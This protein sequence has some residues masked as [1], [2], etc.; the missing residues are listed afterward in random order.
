MLLKASVVLERVIFYALLL[1]I[2]IVATPYGVVNPWR[3]VIETIFECGI[4]ALGAL[5]MIE[6]MLS[7]MWVT[8]RHLLLLPLLAIAV[9]AYVQTLTLGGSTLMPG[10]STPAWQAI[11]FDP[12]ETRLTAGVR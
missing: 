6:G 8:R 7:R 10:I 3:G 9:F 1:L 4:F 2:I 12:Y 5:W 11:S